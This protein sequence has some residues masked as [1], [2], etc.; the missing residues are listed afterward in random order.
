[1]KKFRF[2]FLRLCAYLLAGI[3]CAF[4]FPISIK[5]LW[6]FLSIIFIF[7]IISYF[8]AR[9][10]IFND[11]LPG[12]AAF[13]L[14]FS[15][16]YSA[17]YF[18]MPINQ[19]GHYINQTEN[20]DDSALI[21]AVVSEELKPNDYSE[22]FIIEVENLISS[23]KFQPVH[24]K[25]LLNIQ[26]DSLQQ[27][28]LSPGTRL[29]IPWKPEPIKPPLNPFQFNYKNYM[30]HL[31]VERQMNMLPAKLSIIDKGEINIQAKAWHFR[32]SL[33]GNLRELR[34]GKNELAV[35]QALILGQRR[36]IT[37]KLYQN[38]AAAGAIHILAISGLH[39]GILLLF[40][41]F[42][43]KPLDKVKYGKIGKTILIILLLWAFAFLTGL[44]PSV[45]RAVCMFSFLAVGLQLK[46]K[47]SSLNSL[48]LSLFF[49]LL[50]DPFFIFQVGFQLSYLAV[51]SIIVFQPLIYK[52]F[53]TKWRIPDY[54]WKLIS[55]SIAAQIGVLPLSLY[56]FHQFPGLFLL[57]NIVILPALGFI[58]GIG[59]AVIIL[60][61]VGLLPDILASMLSSILS[62]MNRFI[63][64][65]A[66]LDSFIFSHIDFSLFQTLACYLLLLSLII[67]IEKGNFRRL[68]FF[69]SCI[70][71]FQLASVYKIFD[72][73]DSEAI[74]FHKTRES[75]IGI[76]NHKRLTLLSV[77]PPENK[78]LE[79]YKRENRIQKTE[80]TTI[81]QIFSF[82]NELILVVDTAKNYQ[83]NNFYP[84]KLFLR[85][86]ARINLDRLLNFYN[87][88]EIIADGSNAHYIIK[89]WETTARK[90]KI[91]FHHTGEKGAYIFS[92][93]Q[94]SN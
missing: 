15:L 66:G 92:K 47:T 64:K 25:V 12:I 38:Y 23:E 68:T 76:K 50:V 83:I 30:H 48:F 20:F 10:Q 70:L 75:I 37:D 91:P 27:N 17:A 5:I 62:L 87:P 21:Q 69:L 78:F 14:I 46:R 33:I 31:K 72:I 61:F 49:L 82:D 22:R 63:E 45:V 16:G 90:K 39:I 65:I 42:I 85:N 3:L 55:A 67:L 24:G 53:T 54:F 11:P 8:R 51:F 60:A 59:L 32:E 74:I 19:S 79:D 13:I 93:K 73:S 43:L 4:Y 34:F 77:N 2:I 44:S 81:P 36:E 40:L 89:D 9:K 71:I 86:N 26:K 52:I 88:K 57:S 6:I 35:L 1:M 18:S 29:L 28:T 84:D 7:F 94:L 41:N 58:L 80:I 56:Y